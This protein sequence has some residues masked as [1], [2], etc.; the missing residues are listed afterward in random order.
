MEIKKVDVA[1]VGLGPAGIAAADVLGDTDTLA[2]RCFDMGPAANNRFCT[3]LDN[4][5]CLRRKGCHVLS[6]FGGSS[7]LSGGK[8]STL[9]AGSGLKEIA[10]SEEYVE[11]KMSESLQW[12]QD[13]FKMRE[14]TFSDQTIEKAEESYDDVGFG[15]KYY[16]AYII[17]ENE[18]DV[19]NTY[20]DIRSDLA[21]KGVEM[22]FNTKVTSLTRTES[23]TFELQLLTEDGESTAI[24]DNVILGVGIPGRELVDTLN[25][26]F[27]IDAPPS[28]VELG[29]RLE[30]PKELYPEIDAAH[31][32]LKL[33]VNDARTFCMCKG[34]KLAP[35][36]HEGISI[37]DGHVDQHDETDL[38]NFGI[39]VRMPPDEK[40]GTL[41]KTT[42]HRLREMS[43]GVI[44]RQRLID[45]LSEVPPTKDAQIE[46]SVK[47]WQWGDINQLFPDPVSQKVRENTEYFVSNLLSD[48]YRDR[49]SV[50]APG[51]YYTGY[52]FDV[53]PDYSVLRGLYVVGE[54]TGRMRGILQS[55]CSGR[56]CAENILN[57]SLKDQENHSP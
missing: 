2:V 28:K 42:K 17:E 34:G 26:Q 35:Y 27:G 22:S 54:C 15:F 48:E 51:L 57:Q 52:R 46:S 43:N 16:D 20:A 7:L 30:F 10:D 36:W 25:N 8:I 1:I 18:E 55:F 23:N 39:R 12:F 13:R 5:G 37:L 32:D 11:D 47:Y 31:N 40:N 6:G 14:P 3:V 38:T 24:A 49:V 45:Y 50:Y 4:K 33:K 56:I 21:E 41:Y 44:V 29:V 9:P 19:K 53:N